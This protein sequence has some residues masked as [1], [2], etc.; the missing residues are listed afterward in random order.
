MITDIP[1]SSDFKNAG[2][3]MLELAWNMAIDLFH[4]SHDDEEFW[5]ENKQET[6]TALSLAQQGLEFL[7]KSKICEIHPLLLLMPNQWCGKTDKSFSEMRT[8]DAHELIKC[9][10]SLFAT[11]IPEAFSPRF[12]ELRRKR[13]TIMHSVG[14]SVSGQEVVMA[15]LEGCEALLGKFAWSQLRA[16]YHDHAWR[17]CEKDDVVLSILGELRT[18][19]RLLPPA[20]CSRYFGWKKDSR[21]YQCPECSFL[22][23]EA[24]DFAQLQPNEPT[25]TNVHCHVCNRDFNVTRKKC[26][27]RKCKGN[28]IDAAHGSCLTCG[29]GAP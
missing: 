14:M 28:V 17:E 26:R 3:K 23:G 19:T 25:S 15:I 8:V 20:E 12:D 16:G 7:I 27:D 11:P 4:V 21:W 2:I 22:I 6:S 24:V 5:E 29:H 13:N 9:H 1:D 18:L 10:D